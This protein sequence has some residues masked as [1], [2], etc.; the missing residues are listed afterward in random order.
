VAHLPQYKFS[1]GS[2]TRS[3]KGRVNLGNLGNL[4]NPGNVSD[5]PPMHPN[6]Y[7]ADLGDRDALEALAETPNR[8]RSL[9]EHWTDAQFE[10]SYAPDKWSARLVLVH[11][12]QTELALPTRARMALST[13]GY[14]AQAFSQDEWIGLDASASAGTALDAYT[15]LRT[16]NL[17][18]WRG[19]SAAQR[20]R[21]FHH[22]EYGELTVGWILAQMA[23]H[24]I[25]HLK[26]FEQIR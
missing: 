6:P 1:S 23:G 17:S 7:A 14:T 19:L 25:H 2:A 21:R 24:D 13:P 5:D 16:L 20:D 9:V 15:A 4:G 3:S 11:L 8:I 10:R 12:A 18:M 26:Q 22:P